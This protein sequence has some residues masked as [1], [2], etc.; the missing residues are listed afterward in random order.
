MPVWAERGPP[1]APGFRSGDQLSRLGNK[2]YSTLDVRCFGFHRSYM[3]ALTWQDGLLGDVRRRASANLAELAADYVC[4]LIF[5]GRRTPGMRLQPLELA[6]ELGISATPIREGLALLAHEGL[7]TLEPRRGFSVSRLTPTDVRDIV[8]L[9]AHLESI[10]SCRA[11]AS[12]TE[13]DLLKLEELEESIHSA[14]VGG[15]ADSVAHLNG[16]FH[17]ILPHASHEGDLLRRIR[18]STWRS[19]PARFY[20]TIP[21]FIEATRH[22]SIIEA[23]KDK[24][25]QQLDVAIRSH[26]ETSCGLL[27]KHLEATGFFNH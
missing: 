2:K 18:S 3:G 17:G 11:L 14:A 16:I 12:L 6:E 15:A 27:I 24:D 1:S 5:S 9:D 20:A 7:V 22:D 8:A 13:S 4:D 19:R 25:A 23:V 21:G 26:A 10:L